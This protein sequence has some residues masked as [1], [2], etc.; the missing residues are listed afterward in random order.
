MGCRLIDGL[1][2]RRH[3][4]SILQTLKVFDCKI[5]LAARNFLHMQENSLKNLAGRKID[6]AYARNIIGNLAGCKIDLV[7]ARS[8][9]QFTTMEVARSILHSTNGGCKINL[10]SRKINLAT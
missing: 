3:T 7:Y 1:C 2:S 10:A 6:L 5:D 9:L 4:R 8:I